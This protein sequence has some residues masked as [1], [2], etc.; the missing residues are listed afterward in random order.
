[1]L[2]RLGPQ[3]GGLVTWRDLTA[4][5]CSHPHCCSV[6]YLLR[7][8][9]GAWRSLTALIGHDRLKQWLDLEPDLLANRI[10]DDAIP[11]TLRTVVKESLLDL[12]SRAVVAC[13][14]R[15][16]P[17]IWRDICENCDLGIGTLTTLAAGALPG[18]RSGCGAMLG[19]RVKRITVKPFMDMNTMIEERL[20]PVLRPRGDGEP[21]STAPTSARRSARSR[22]GRHC[23]ASR[24]STATG[25]RS[26]A[27]EV[28]TDPRQVDPSADRAR[29]GAAEPPYDPLRLC[30]FAT[31]ALLGWLLGPV[32]LRGLRRAGVRRLLEGPAR[33]PAAVEAACSAT[34]GSCSVYLGALALVGVAG[35]AVAVSGGRSGRCGDPAQPT[36]PA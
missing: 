23:R 3:T 14:T 21:P 4:L 10:A 16:W 22:P 33:R 29:T 5:P 35:V 2:A 28:V 27:T 9:S 25:R 8:D 7:D 32:A 1:M 6:G 19:E 17:T 36:A 18:Q 34:P 30:I 20:D 31:V 11:A 24:I 12:L 15:R 13:P 26:C